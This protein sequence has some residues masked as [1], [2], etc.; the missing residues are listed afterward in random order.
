MNFGGHHDAIGISNLNDADKFNMLVKKY[1]GEFKCTKSENLV[2][3]IPLNDLGSHET[4][5]KVRELEPIGNGLKLPPAIVNVPSDK[6]VSKQIGKNEHWK[7]FSI[8]DDSG[9]KVFTVKDWNYDDRNK[10]MKESDGNVEMLVSLEINN[11]NGSHLEGTTAYKSDFFPSVKEQ[12]VNKSV[13]VPQE[14]I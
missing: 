2:L 1:Q 8:I 14:K 3:D 4:L 11:F 6:I 7:S 10:A 9:N 13:A 5:K 12:S